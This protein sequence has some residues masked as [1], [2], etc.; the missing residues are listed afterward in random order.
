MFP[1]V[2]GFIISFSSAA[3][4]VYSKFIEASAQ[5]FIYNFEAKQH[6]RCKKQDNQK[7]IPVNDKEIILVEV[8]DGKYKFTPQLCVLKI[9]SNK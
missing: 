3:S 1:T 7:V 2:F 4:P 6:S 5:S 8:K 9:G